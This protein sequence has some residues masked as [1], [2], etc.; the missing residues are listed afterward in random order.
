MENR[1]GNTYFRHG[2]PADMIEKKFIEAKN[3]LQVTKTERDLKRDIAFRSQNYAKNINRRLKNTKKTEIVTVRKAIR[4]TTGVKKVS[5]RVVKAHIAIL[6]AEKVAKRVVDLEIDESMYVSNTSVT[7]AI[8][9]VLQAK[10][11]YL[12][13]CEQSKKANLEAKDAEEAFASANKNFTEISKI[14]N[15]SLGVSV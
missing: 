10:K 4:E 11:K 13:A 9:N 1:F 3:A 14:L 6:R 7:K 8:K 15:D 2:F 12:K 5:D